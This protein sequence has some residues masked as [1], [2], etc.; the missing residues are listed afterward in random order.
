MR[1]FVLALTLAV[2]AAAADQPTPSTDAVAAPAAAAASFLPVVDAAAVTATP[3]DADA[4]SSSSAAPSAAPLDLMS[5]VPPGATVE[6]APGAQDMLAALGALFAGAGAGAG[7]AED[8]SGFAGGMAGTWD[9]NWGSTT[10]VYD[11]T[12]TLEL[13]LD[14]AGSGKINIQS[15]TL[16][17][18]ECAPVAVPVGAPSAW[19]SA[20]G[21]IACSIRRND[22]LVQGMVGVLRAG[23][24]FVGSYVHFNVPGLLTAMRLTKRQ[25]PTPLPQRVLACENDVAQL[26]CANAPADARIRVTTAMFGRD[27]TRTCPYPGG[28]QAMQNTGCRYGGALAAVKSQCDGQRECAVE[29]TNTR[30]GGDPCYGTFKYLRV[31]YT[32]A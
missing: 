16:G 1:A 7:G 9:G 22:G 5:F 17:A 13:T 8:L 19:R 25:P 2:A 29:A 23:G 4:P 24:E 26:S 32:C 31:A 28:P 30:F 18:V 15:G 6:T 27:D 21:Q 10:G 14:A 20:G 12:H 3:A 11:P